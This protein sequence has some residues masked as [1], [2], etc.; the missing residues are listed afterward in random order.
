[1]TYTIE[2]VTRYE[3]TSA[4]FLEPHTVRLSPRPDGALEV[5]ACERAVSPQP[6]AQTQALDHNGN[7]VERYW[8]SGTSDHLV[9]RRTLK[10]RTLRDN[11]FDYIPGTETEQL[12][13][14]YPAPVARTLA[15]YM[16]RSPSDELQEFL[17]GLTGPSVYERVRSARESGIRTEHEL[18]CSEF[19]SLLNQSIA[20]RFR[21]V[22]REE[23]EA[24]PAD[25]TLRQTEATCR[26][27][28]VLFC[29]A[30]RELGIASRF[31]SGYQA[32]DPEQDSRDLHAWAEIYTIDGGWRGFD[33]TLGLAVADEHVALA[34]AAEPSGAAPVEGSFRG[35]GVRSRLQHDIHLTTRP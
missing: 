31:V 8:F 19:V 11:P 5:L 22:V 18:R 4:V 21:T 10:L 26:D 35:T 24:W 2:H 1:M 30:C 12:P 33:P 25:H 3:Y 6:T 23:G 16:E 17:A 27:L 20:A 9:I 15:P 7:I 28:T 32:G 14:A 13:P 34:S 29:A